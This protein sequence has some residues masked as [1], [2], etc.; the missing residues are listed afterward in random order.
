M[1]PKKA[2][3]KDAK[4]KPGAPGSGGANGLLAYVDD[5][6][7]DAPTLPQLNNYIFT[8]LNVFKYKANLQRI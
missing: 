1:P 3:A 2:D 7:A 8:T 4:G 5:D 6:F